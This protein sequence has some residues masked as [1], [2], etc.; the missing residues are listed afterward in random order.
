MSDLRVYRVDDSTMGGMLRWHALHRGG[1][2]AVVCGGDRRTWRE[3]NAGANRLANALT[4][5][6]LAEGD[7]VAVLLSNCVEYVEIFQGVAKLG[8][9]VTPVNFHLAADEV[10]FILDDCEAQALI[11]D[12]TKANLI[13]QLDASGRLHVPEAKRIA[14]GTADEPVKA[15]AQLVAGA[16]DTEPKVDI[17]GAEPFFQGYTSGTTGFPKGCVQ[18]QTAFVD[19]YKRGLLA[20][21]YGAPEVMLI[22]GPLFHEAP[23]LFTLGHLFFGGTV[24]VLPAFTPEAALEAIE[25]ER[26]S[27][28]GFAVPT[29]LDRITACHD[30]RDIS[31]VRRIITAGAPLRLET[32]DATL[33]MFS[34]AEL[35]EFYGATEVGLVTDVGHR[36]HR[37]RGCTAGQ[38]VPGVGLLILE[39]DG[40]VVAP[41]DVGLVFISPLMMEGYYKREEAT[42]ETTRSFDGVTWFTLGDMGYL[43]KEGYLY[44]V[45]RRSDMIITGGENVYPTEVE[46]V[47]SRHAAVADVAVIGLPDPEWGEAVTAVIVPAGEMPTLNDIKD[48]CADKLARYKVP[49]RVEQASELPR[50]A[51]G[52]VQKHELRASLA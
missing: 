37:N 49:K 26:C 47:L 21:R 38:P 20:Y 17:D 19:H 39:D 11:Y 25:R 10:A 15:Y 45:D 6:G 33:D 27:V 32:M 3:L 2:T 5:L 31:S 7:R 13:H 34:S 23:A 1:R 9:T 50:T 41:G 28:I 12:A 40:E 44:L 30:D 35:H 14:L 16:A 18:T 51:S 46:N 48:F 24:V 52:K 42:A 29:M 8:M 4:E 22:P 43:D 36:A